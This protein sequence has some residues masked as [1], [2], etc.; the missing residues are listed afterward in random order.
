[1]I[2]VYR[3][4]KFRTEVMYS[5]RVNGK[6]IGHQNNLTLFNVRMKH[7]TPNALRKVRK[8]KRSVICWL[9]G[10]HL[11]HHFNPVGMRRLRCD[12]KKV[13]FFCDA[14]TGKRVDHASCVVLDDTGVY[15]RE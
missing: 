4:L 10:E 5:V 2:Q 13:D 14:E 7:A 1:M 11:E 8:T 15:Y 12:P 3:N 6:V 9:V